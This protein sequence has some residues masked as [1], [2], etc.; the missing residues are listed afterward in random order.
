MPKKLPL[1]EI[2]YKRILNATRYELDRFLKENGY[3]EYVKFN[4]SRTYLAELFKEKA[5]ARGREYYV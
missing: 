2:T 1:G 3:Q 4:Y 5:K